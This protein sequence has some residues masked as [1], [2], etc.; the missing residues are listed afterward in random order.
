MKNK[1]GSHYHSIWEETQEAKMTCSRGWTCTAAPGGYPWNCSSALSIGPL[2]S[3][4]RQ[5]LKALLGQKGE[6]RPT[7]EGTGTAKKLSS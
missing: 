4:K 5:D 2:F 7:K 3:K 6:P 1:T